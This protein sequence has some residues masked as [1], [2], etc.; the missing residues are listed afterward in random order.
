[1]QDG[2]YKIAT[3]GPRRQHR[4]DAHA[5]LERARAGETWEEFCDIFSRLKAIARQNRVGALA[6]HGRGWRVSVNFKTGVVYGPCRVDKSDADADLKQIR[7]GKTREECR[8]IL[9]QLKKPKQSITSNG[10]E[11]ETTSRKRKVIVS[12]RGSISPHDNDGR[13]TAAHPLAV[14]PPMAQLD[15]SRSDSNGWRVTT[16]QPG[17]M[18]SF[19]H[20]PYRACKSIAYADLKQIRRD[21]TREEYCDIPRQSKEPDRVP[22]GQY[23]YVCKEHSDAAISRSY[24]MRNSPTGDRLRSGRANRKPVSHLGTTR[25]HGN[26]W[27]VVATMKNLTICGPYRVNKSDADADLIQ[28][29][30]A[31]SRE[32]YD[33][34]LRRLKQTIRATASSEI[35]EETS[36]KRDE[37]REMPPQNEKV[38][39]SQLLP[40]A[41]KREVD[42][43]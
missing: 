37:V 27:R 10:T 11:E 32:E 3:V 23:K 14:H 13:V 19:S 36:L 26:G 43:R 15:T 20:G 42:D 12:R 33:R 4:R 9:L 35:E 34:I 2:E 22:S 41:T 31:K 18:M 21:R 17:N 16:E 8:S 24:R 6:P 38:Q 30:T 39:E 29:R 28:A 25:A 5:D 40:E 7:T 1:M